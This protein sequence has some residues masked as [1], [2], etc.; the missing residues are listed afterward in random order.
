MAAGLNAMQAKGD[1]TTTQD[2][3]VVNA[4]PGVLALG[5]VYHPTETSSG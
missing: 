2:A 3:Y 4:A 1:P 5:G